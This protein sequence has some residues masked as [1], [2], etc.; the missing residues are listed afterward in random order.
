[1]TTADSLA[2]LREK[3][4]RLPAPRVAS[5]VAPQGEACWHRDFHWHHYHGNVAVDAL[6]QADGAPFGIAAPPSRWAFLDTETTGI[7]GGAGTYAFLIGVGVLMGDT[8][9]IHQFFLRDFHEEPQQLAAV[10][11]LLADY[12]VLVT[13]NGKTFDGP[14]LETRY[15]LARREP[16]H[17]RLQHVDL[18]HSARR[19]WKLR[20]KSCRLVELESAI[21]GYQR[22]DDVPGYLVPPLYF[23]YLR[24]GILRRLEPVFLHN[25]LDILSLACL[26]SVVLAAVGDP[27]RAPLAHGTDLLSLARWVGREGRREAALDLYQRALRCGLPPEGEVRARWEMAAV[28]KR[29]RNY[30]AALPLW[31]ALGTAEAFEELAKYYE[32][33]AGDYPAALEGAREAFRLCPTGRS[34]RRVDRLVRK[35][36]RSHPKSPLLC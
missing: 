18:L 2:R 26:T 35:S 7:S 36:G 21:L 9:R 13:Y 24:Y 31:R 11:R 34:Q 20:M 8:F 1:M 14:L 32:H 23:D 19:I 29:M 28:H 30:G 15:R 22:V 12:D 33:R 16:P 6:S 3:L 5:P 27:A 4:S 10:E 17:Q 25:R